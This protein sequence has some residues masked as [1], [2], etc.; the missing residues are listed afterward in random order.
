[1]T[2]RRYLGFHVAF[3]DTSAYFALADETDRNHRYAHAIASRLSMERLGITHAFTFDANF[4]QYGR[5]A[6]LTPP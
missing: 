5:F 4:T 1:M 2:P 6:P 3:T